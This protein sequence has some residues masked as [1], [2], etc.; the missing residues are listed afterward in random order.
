MKLKSLT[1]FFLSLLVFASCKKENDDPITQEPTPS[2][3]ATGTLVGCEGAFGAN[4]ASVSWISAAGVVEQDIFSKANGFGP[5]DV[6]QSMLRT[7]NEV[8]LVVNN[9]QKVEVVDVESFGILSTITGVDYPRHMVQV[10]E[11]KFYL[12]NGAMAGT[13]QVID[14]E[15]YTISGSIPVGNGPEKMTISGDLVFVANS[16]GWTSDQTVTV[17]NTQDDTAVSM[18]DVGDRPTSI[19]TDQ[20]GHVWVM[21]AGEVEYDADWNVVGHTEATLQQIDPVSFEVEQ[22]ITIG[23]LGD[24]PSQIAYD[25][26]ADR[27]LIAHNGILE[28]TMDG[29]VDQFATTACSTISVDAVSG[30]IYATSIPD[31]VSDSEVV[32]LDSEGNHIMTYEVGL[33]ANSILLD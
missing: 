19:V 11:E 32:R 15:G 12:T 3:Y 29:T 30:E 8:F 7:N 24:H 13:V 4:N 20:D 33:G 2:S 10:S 22:V 25:A 6:L 17:I 14:A 16:G 26:V 28:V 27:I 5:G 18:I 23:E 21:C 1:F 9:S 31:F